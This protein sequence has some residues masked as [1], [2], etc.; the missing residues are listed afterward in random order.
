MEKALLVIDMQNFC[1]G[2][3]QAALF[4]YKNLELIKNV[5]MIISEYEPQNVYYIVNIMEDNL[6][7]KCAPF[8]AFAGSY[9]ADIVSDLSV[10]NNKIFKKYESNA[11]S[12][13][14]LI[15]ELM[16][17]NIIEVEIVG[18]DGGGC[19]ALTAFAAL[20]L[21]FKVIMNTRGIGTTFNDKAD[22]YNKQLKEQGVQ[23]K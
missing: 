17:S 11:F 13:K 10:V 16:N 6:S 20:E 3:N 4:K 21:G 19:V 12:N 15:E 9:E 5:N 22:K 7:N 8:K 14:K 2:K 18:V 23:F 1:V